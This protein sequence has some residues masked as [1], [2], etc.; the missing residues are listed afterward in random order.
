MT[1]P[2]VLVLAARAAAARSVVAESRGEGLQLRRQ[3]RP[4]MRSR[5]VRLAQTEAVRV[6]AIAVAVLGGGARGGAQG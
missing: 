2:V 5:Y 3:P 1:R 4:A 6:V